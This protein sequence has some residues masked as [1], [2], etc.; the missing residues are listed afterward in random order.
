MNKLAA[1]AERM[2][3]EAAEKGLAQRRLEKGLILTLRRD[4]PDWVLSLTRH[5]VRAS[6]L[7]MKICLEAFQAPDGAELEGEEINEYQV[8]RVRWLAV[9]QEALIED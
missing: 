3:I 4:G 1:I 8:R 2:K 7:E 9:G 5:L 6:D